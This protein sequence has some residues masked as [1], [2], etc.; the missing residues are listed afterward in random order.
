[1]SLE[2]FDV[3][4]C[5]L[6]EFFMLFASHGLDDKPIVIC[7]EEEAA[8]LAGTFTSLEDLIKIVQWA[9]TLDQDAI[10]TKVLPKD[11]LELLSLVECD[12]HF[13][14]DLS[15]LML[16]LL[17]VLGPPS[18]PVTDPL[19]PKLAVFDFEIPELQACV[20]SL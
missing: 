15:A 8:T 12:Y 13:I 3:A 20:L 7:V 16:Q 14:V 5:Y 6:K 2:M 9:Q 11:L 19:L 18:F 1:M 10:V 4:V 17:L